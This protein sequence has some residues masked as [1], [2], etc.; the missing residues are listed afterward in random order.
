[1][2]NV[3]H[4]IVDFAAALK[5]LAEAQSDIAEIVTKWDLICDT[6]TPRTVKI[7]LSDGIHTVDNLAKIREDLVKGLSLEN[8]EVYSI[9][10]KVRGGPGV[11]YMSA[12]RMASVTSFGTQGQ[13]AAVHDPYEKY[14]GNRGILRNTRN[15]F[16]SCCMAQTST[17]NVYFDE[18]A[19]FI[20]LGYPASPNDEHIS[21]Y[22][23]YIKTRG[24]NTEWAQNRQ[25]CTLVTFISANTSYDGSVQYGP[26]TLHLHMSSDDR[27]VTTVSIE[28][29]KMATFL[30]WAAPGQDGIPILRV[31][32]QE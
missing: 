13:T 7:E 12:F 10:F 8:P 2:T 21:E 15:T 17:I 9:K 31:L 20:W 6:T 5:M 19:R 16:Y 11:G 18:L 24:W 30:I 14:A 4:A 32:D 3:P 23:I 28:L 26:V 25:Y 27:Q 29:G 22:N 1:M